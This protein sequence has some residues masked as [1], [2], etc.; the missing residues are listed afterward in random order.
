MM[1][2]LW[3]RFAFRD[4]IRSM[5][6]VRAGQRLTA[7]LL[8]SRIA[9]NVAPL[10]PAINEPAAN[11]AVLDFQSVHMEAGPFSDADVG[12]TH[13]ASQ[14]E[15]WTT[16]VGAQRVWLSLTADPIEL[17]HA[18][19]ADGSFEGSHTGRTELFPSTSYQVRIRFRDSSGE[20][21]TEWS[22]FSTRSFSTTSG[23]T[24][25]AIVSGLTSPITMDIADD[26]RVFVAFQNGVIRVIE[27]DQMLPT[28]FATLVCD[29]SGERGLQGIELDPNFETNGYIYVYYTASQPSSHNRVSRLRADPT[30][31]NVMMAGGET[32]LLD[33]PL[34][35]SL[36]QNNNPIWHMGGAIHVALDG[37]LRVQTGDHLNSSLVQNVDTLIGKVLRLNTDGTVPTNNPF[38][39]AGAITPR[40]YVWALGLRNPFS[41]DLNPATGQYLIGDVGEGSWEEINDAT[42]PGRNFG[43][44]NTEGDFTQ[45]SF[46][47]FTRPLLAYNHS[48]DSAITGGVFYNPPVNQ[49]PAQYQGKFFY[50]QFTAGRIKFIDPANAA[51]TTFISGE[52]YP[53]NLEVAPNGSLYYIAR[54]AGAGGAPG[55]GTGKVIKV[56]YTANIPP[57][58]L[59]HPDN[60]LVSV[61]F[62]AT[63]S[64]AAQGSAPLNYK[65]QRKN[66]SDPDFVDVPGATSSTYT[67]ASAPASAN[68]AQ[69]RVV[70]TN[71]FGSATSNPATL[72]V[73]T[74]LPPVATISSPTNGTLYQGGQTFAFSGSGFDNEDGTLPTSAL[75]WWIDFHHDTHAHPFMAPTSGISS[76]QFTIPIVSETSPNVW[77][78][79]YLRVVD[80]LGLTHETYANVVPR[81]ADYTITASIPGLSLNLDGQPHTAPHSFE[82]VVNLQRSLGAPLIQNFGGQTYQFVSWSDGGAANHNILT[83]AIGT[84]YTAIYQL[85]PYIYVSNL[86]FVGTPT[87][88]WGPVEL[89]RSNGETGATDGRTISLRGQTYAKG[90]GVHAASNVTYNLGGSYERFL[91]VI[92]ID[93]ETNGAGS[94]IFQVYADNVLV[95]NSA[96]LTGSSPVV[97]VDLSVV[98]VQQLRLVVTDAGNGNG[99][100]HADWADARLTATPPGPPVL[101]AVALAANQVA[102]SWTDG[103]ANETGFRVERS[104]S[105]IDRWEA[106][107]TVA[108]NT[109]SLLDTTATPLSLNYYRVIAIGPLAETLS[110]IAQ[111]VT[112]DVIRVNFQTDSAPTHPG[113]FRDIG[114]VYADRGNGYSYGWNQDITAHARY[115]QAANSP[116]LRYDTFNHLQKPGNETAAWEI[117]LPNGQYAVHFVSGDPS[118]FDGN[119]VLDVEHVVANL[120]APTTAQRWLE[121]T[122]IV[123]VSDGRLT[124]GNAPGAVN[125]KLNF[126]DID[127]LPTADIIDVSP[128]PRNAPVDSIVI[129]FREPVTGFDRADLSLVRDGGANLLTA[130]Q[131]LSSTDNRRFTLSGLTGV[132]TAPGTYVLTLNAAGSGIVDSFGAAL[133]AS[134]ADSFIVAATPTTTTLVADPLA[135]T[136]GTLVMLTATVAPFPGS[137]GTVTFFDGGIALAGGANIPVSGGVAVFSTS[138]LADGSHPLTALYNGSANFAASPASNAQT[139]VVS[140]AATAPNVVSVTTNGNIPLL[141]TLGNAQR[142]RIASLQ[143]VFDQPVALDDNALAL[144]LHTNNVSFDGEPRPDGFGS[145]PTSL[146]ISTPDAGV[147]WIVAFS[148]NT[149]PDSSAFPPPPDNHYSLK[150]GVYSFSI[151]A[152]KVHPAGVPSVNGAADSTTVFHRLFGDDN[153]PEVEGGNFTAILG[154]SDNFAFRSS[155]NNFPIDRASFDYDGDGTIG[156]ADNFQFRSRFNRPLTWSV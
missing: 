54:G 64:A 112:S 46:P 109:T 1:M 119:Y 5:R 31:T 90:L 146:L 20:A 60:V 48:E 58:V 79:V 129:D 62:D 17:V 148:G 89:D 66:P 76:G 118:N 92:G 22:P 88:G 111:A 121:A 53:M 59:D 124:I 117:A 71:A 51:T 57:T 23:F 47:N 139:V 40:D 84:T 10:A 134:A 114:V 120:G 8:E 107:G 86:P 155:F 39:T 94:V 77:Y 122:V 61:G 147:T 149:D 81:K 80:S 27:N 72:T 82:G 108:P 70:A 75:T 13:T 6:G 78:R 98:G 131:S 32:V 137:E 104:P 141:A 87:N 68:G 133:Q 132:T 96:T 101:N 153:A 99:S 91:S 152:S 145:L 21:A 69:F 55:T 127:P 36:P 93:D 106:I 52:S 26:G 156:V 97:S 2:N 15:I 115:R 49:F 95:Y 24:S 128:D 123:T 143:I 12:D 37:T 154:V 63:F 9:F 30:N 103:S 110:N 136:G 102:L 67:L 18:H 83:P 140:P 38:Y 14:W 3:R 126:V 125:N 50:S 25:T 138:A 73:T 151:D 65:W 11:G 29:G 113:Y 130:A 34:F 35:S 45:A 116:D 105:G 16:G 7:E 100:D 150:D 41:G 42:L 142:S 28:P 43:W 135:T 33:L 56:Q 19:L 85:A 74:T 144:A 44:P 4:R